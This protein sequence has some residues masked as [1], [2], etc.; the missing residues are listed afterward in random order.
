ATLLW[1]TGCSQERFVQLATLVAVAY[2][3]HSMLRHRRGDPLQAW[4]RHVQ[5]LREMRVQTVAS[6]R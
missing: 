3:T 2:Q 6:V 4:Q 5:V 1:E